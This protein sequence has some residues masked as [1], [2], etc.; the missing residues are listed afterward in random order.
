M[1]PVEI[2]QVKVQGEIGR[3]IDITIDNNVLVI[4]VEK[5]FIAPFRQRSREGGY[6]GLGKFIDSLVRF[7]AYSGDEK[8]LALKRHVVRETIATQEADGYIGI[9][10]PQRRM[11]RLWDIHEMGYLVL[12][13]TADHRYFGEKDSLE[14]ARKLAD[15]IIDRWSVDPARQ[16]DGWVSTY[17]ATTGL[18]EAMLALHEESGDPQ[19]LDFCVRH[20]KLADWDTP[21][22]QGRWGNL[23][24]HAYYHLCHCLSQLRLYQIRP[25]AALLNQSRRTL[26]F[27]LRQNGLLAPGLC[28]YHECWHSNQQGF[29]KLG[30]TCATAYL[31][32]W[33]DALLQIDGSSLYGDIMERAIYNGLFAAQSPD[34]RRLRY[35]APFEGRREF[36]RGDTY[37]C[38]CNFR[39]II[40]ELP[41]MI[42]YVRDGGLAINLY[43]QS[44]ATVSLREGLSVEVSQETDYPNTG[45]VTIRLKPSTAATFP[46]ALRIPRWCR[47]ARLAINDDEVATTAAGGS[48]HAVTRTW[49][50]GDRISLHMPMRWRAIRG[51]QSQA[52]RAAVM[53]GPLLF[54]L[55]PQR[56]EDLNR[57]TLK[58]LR[59]DPA[60]MKLA[61]TN[62]AIRP[63]GLRCEASFWKPED[64]NAAGPAN[65]KLTLSEY[66]DPGCE[67]TYFLIPSPETDVLVDDEL[68]GCDIPF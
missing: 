29:Y 42:Y 40:A 6:I 24:G 1:S 9:C 39:R 27:L 38:P 33:L 57:E 61:G 46:V 48:F 17:V 59:L 25:V 45:D 32:R 13:L 55:N 28:G 30:E 62:D 43:S 52:G 10:I 68:A 31:L 65:V 37:C 26:D 18:E 36:F 60:S 64:Y 23:E 67:W 56:Q 14:A 54:C 66:A 51:R 34:G 47:Q 35:Y 16:T 8:V 3:R 44:T 5:D 50:A 41:G 53:R 20:R 12:G 49:R 22:I 2:D 63:D 58:L 11:W 19:Y 4:D 7:A 15:Y 21:L